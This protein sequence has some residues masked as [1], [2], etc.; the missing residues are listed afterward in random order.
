MHARHPDHGRR[1]VSPCCWC[2]RDSP[3]AASRGLYLDYAFEAVSALA[4]VGLS[5][6][7]T[8]SLLPAGKLIIIVLM[9]IGRV[10]LLT[11]AFTIVRR[12]RGTA[13]HYSEENIMIG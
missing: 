10:G 13:V 12:A 7:V 11:L 3:A 4:T 9:F 5:L 2:R 1:P 6:G 8:A